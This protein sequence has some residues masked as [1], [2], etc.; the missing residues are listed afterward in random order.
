MEIFQDIHS[1][2]AYFVL[3]L[4]IIT[5]VKTLLSLKKE[6]TLQ[7]V[8]LP[9]FTLI[10]SHIQLFIGLAWYFMS[11]AYKGFKANGMSVTMK[12]S[13]ARLIA[14]EHPLMM[15][16]AIVFITIGF[17]KHKKKSTSEGKF[18]TLAIWYGLALVMILIRIPWG[19]WFN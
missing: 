5:V 18:K 9:L 2:W 8:R 1:K 13:A 7:D 14:V 4:L 15:I 6:Y 17:S 12:D 16:L 3:A 10:A 11:P 19:N